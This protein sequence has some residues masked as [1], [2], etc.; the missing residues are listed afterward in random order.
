ME[1]PKLQLDSTSNQQRQQLIS[2]YIKQVISSNK[3]TPIITG[4]TF[5]NDEQD[6]RKPKWQ[7]LF[8]QITHSG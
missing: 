3:C 2:E 8:E 1:F 5:F 6:N 7:Y 4:G